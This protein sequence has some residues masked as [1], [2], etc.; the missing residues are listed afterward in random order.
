MRESTFIMLEQT[1]NVC[2]CMVQCSFLW[3][4]MHAFLPYQ[5]EYIVTPT[6]LTQCTH[7]EESRDR[8]R[9]VQGFSLF[10]NFVIKL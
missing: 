6:I 8:S 7:S 1:C 4:I 3:Y 5:N 9:D 2:D 10:V